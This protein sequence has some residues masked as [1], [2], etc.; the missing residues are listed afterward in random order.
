MDGDDSEDSDIEVLLKDISTAV[1]KTVKQ[2]ASSLLEVLRRGG[3]VRWTPRTREIIIDGY[4]MPG[5]NALDL[6]VHAVSQRQS[7]TPVRGSPGPPPG[8]RAFARVL[9]EENVPRVL[10]RNRRRWNEIFDSDK[11]SSFDGWESA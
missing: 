2:R 10:V 11:P 8:F 4:R 1:P 7:T 6:A 9:R 5:T 3:R